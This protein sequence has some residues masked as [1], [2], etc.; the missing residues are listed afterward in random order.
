MFSSMRKDS[1]RTRSLAELIDGG[2]K[3]KADAVSLR[4]KLQ[5]KG[6]LTMEE[7]ASLVGGELDD[8]N[9]DSSRKPAQSLSP[10]INLHKRFTEG[11]GAITAVK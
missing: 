2:S 8:S 3:S 11:K 4:D 1:S 9:A 10:A 6:Q 7:D 5:L